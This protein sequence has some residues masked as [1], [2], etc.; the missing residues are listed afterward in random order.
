[1][2]DELDPQRP[3]VREAVQELDGKAYPGSRTH[4]RWQ[5]IRAELLRLADEN[6]QLRDVLADRDM[7]REMAAQANKRAA[8]AEAELAALRGRVAEAPIST[9]GDVHAETMGGCDYC[10][11]QAPPQLSGK[12]VRLVVE[13]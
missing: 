10:M 11:L 1:M 3:E 12:R 2:T 9:C 7:D 6:A 13:E 4:E 5:T 8:H